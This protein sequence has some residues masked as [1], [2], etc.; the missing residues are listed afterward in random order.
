MDYNCRNFSRWYKRK[1]QRNELQKKYYQKTREQRLEYQH[2]YYEKNK[3][4][5][6]EKRKLKYNMQSQSKENFKKEIMKL[7]E[8]I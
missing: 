8:E 6:L 7:L 2:E 3:E 4:K 5:I 1:E